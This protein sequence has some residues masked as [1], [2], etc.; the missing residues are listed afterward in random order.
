MKKLNLIN[1]ENS[2][3]IFAV[4]GMSF[5]GLQ[6]CSSGDTKIEKELK[7]IKA[8]VE[9]NDG[10]SGGPVDFTPVSS[11]IT[12]LESKIKEVDNKVDNL[13]CADKSSVENLTKALNALDGTSMVDIAN[14]VGKKDGGS[15]LYGETDEIKRYFTEGKFKNKD[16]GDIS[17]S[18]LLK[19]IHSKASEK[20]EVHTA[21]DTFKKSIK[22]ADV[23][24]GDKLVAKNNAVKDLFRSL[25]LTVDDALTIANEAHLKSNVGA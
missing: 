25:D 2:R 19:D 15:G 20:S 9:K 6:S 5:L 23:A 14:A 13:K 1:F 16:N 4:C 12:S 24:G 22:A 7:Y 18:D 11:L 3:K 21:V 8:K 10:N 17:L